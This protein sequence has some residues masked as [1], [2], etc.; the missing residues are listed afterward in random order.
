MVAKVALHKVLE[1]IQSRT[2]SEKEAHR[3]FTAKPKPGMPFDFDIGINTDT[4]DVE[5]APSA[6]ALAGPMLR[7]AG[8]VLD[9][10]RIAATAKPASFKR[11]LP[12]IAEGDSWFK[13]P[14]AEPVVPSTM[15]D[16]LQPNFATMN[17]AH[18]GDTLAH[19]V[20]KGQFW[21]FLKSSD[22]LLFSAGGN[23][24]LGGGELWRFLEL[25]DVDHAKASDAPYY[26][27]PDFFANLNVVIG[28][29]DALIREVKLRTPHVIVLGHG[30]DYA[31]PQD[32]GP[33]LG[34]PMARQGLDPLH[35]PALCNAIVKV[36]IDHFNNRLKALQGAHEK[37]FRFVD[38]RGT[39]K[40][41]E[42]WD[43][44]HP[45]EAAARKLSAKLVKAVQGLPASGDT[46]ESPFEAHFE[47]MVA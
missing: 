16:F 14:E 26:L 27:N 30:Y 8:I 12:L 35:R 20:L 47:K 37:N 2:L 17:L 45:R 15:I 25:F 7:D 44:L 31:I 4:V 19:M 34:G 32:N 1:K 43:E 11:K 40:D 3:F 6:Q 33:W 23:D 10:N 36:M 22:V 9:F 21:P 24:V 42:W 18:W 41:T 5:N 39:I 13:L 28:T 29:Y 38:L 46:H